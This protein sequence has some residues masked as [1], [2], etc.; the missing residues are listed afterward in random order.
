MN[1]SDSVKWRDLHCSFWLVYS[2]WLMGTCLRM[3]SRR[4]SEEMGAASAR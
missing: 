1:W 3:V 2:S 4:S